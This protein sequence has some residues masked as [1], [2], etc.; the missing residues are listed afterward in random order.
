MV[1]AVPF[2][3]AIADSDLVKIDVEGL[4]AQLFRSS[5]IQLTQLKP[6]VMVEIHTYNR[7][8]RSLVPELM[9]DLDAAVY[10]M[11]RD[12]LLPVG[13]DVWHDGSLEDFHTWDYLIVPSCRASLIDGLVRG[14]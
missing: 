11:R 14:P 13:A 3:A 6:V 2:G 4:E 8:L 12:H 10:A 9:R 1:D 7:E 5:W